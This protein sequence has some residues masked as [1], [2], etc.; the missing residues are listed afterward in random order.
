M[1]SIITC[2]TRLL[3]LPPLVLFFLLITS[4]EPG[5]AGAFL[6]GTALIRTITALK[7]QATRN[8]AM[9]W[10]IQTHPVCTLASTQYIGPARLHST[11]MDNIALVTGTILPIIQGAK[12]RRGSTG[13]G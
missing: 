13:Y 3:F 7:Q 12:G 1:L 2:I 5:G 11:S 8:T 4:Q 9:H 10:N 6:A